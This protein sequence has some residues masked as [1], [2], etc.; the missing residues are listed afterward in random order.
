MV[1]R[2]GVFLDCRDDLSTRKDVNAA[3]LETTKLLII[4][5]EIILNVRLLVFA[6]PLAK[7]AASMVPYLV[8]LVAILQEFKSL[9]LLMGFGM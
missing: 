9:K 5:T 1:A 6:P 8:S 2:L 4:C 7:I 3:C